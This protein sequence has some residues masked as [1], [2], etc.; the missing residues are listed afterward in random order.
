LQEQQAAATNRQQPF[1]ICQRP[2]GKIHRYTDTPI[3]RYT[4]TDTDTD[5]DTDAP[6]YTAFSAP[7]WPVFEQ[8][9]RSAGL[10]SLHLLLNTH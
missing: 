3:L 4:D 5:A 1:C 9:P 2:L 8:I 10:I 6:F 7:F